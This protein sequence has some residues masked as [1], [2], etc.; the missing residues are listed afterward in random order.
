MRSPPKG[1]DD[2]LDEV[3]SIKEYDPARPLE[4]N[5]LRLTFR[6]TRHYIDTYS[7]RAEH[8]NASVV[9][10]GDTAPCDSV[11]EHAANCSL[12]LCEATLGLGHEEGMRGHSS[13]EEAGEMAQ[14]AG[15]HRLVLT[16]YGST[17]APDEL[18]EAAQSAF[19]GRVFDGRRRHRTI[20]RRLLVR[21]Q[22]SRLRPAPHAAL[23]GGACG[24]SPF[25][26]ER[27]G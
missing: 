26:Q 5:D 15:V 7:I 1:P 2:F 22:R 25:S 6:H 21:R 14:L 10:S 20:R 8:G 9:Y 17:Y 11:V 18:E 3:L 13:A 27:E 4:I 12:F 23:A 24:G 19:S 16:H